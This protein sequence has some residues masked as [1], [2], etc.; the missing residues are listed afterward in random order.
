VRSSSKFL[1]FHRS[2]FGPIYQSY[3]PFFTLTQD[4]GG[5]TDIERPDAEDEE[6]AVTGF[7]RRCDTDEEITDSPLVA[8]HHGREI[9]ENVANNGVT[10]TT[11]F[12]PVQGTCS[13]MTGT[14]LAKNAVKPASVRD[15][16]AM[17]RHAPSLWSVNC[18]GVALRGGQRRSIAGASASHVSLSIS[19]AMPYFRCHSFRSSTGG[20][21]TT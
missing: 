3:G 18:A 15:A 10:P 4:D 20:T 9:V 11:V 21:S 7:L 16:R 8:F 6:I 17:R 2:E 5:W 14:D 19:A 12:S 1:A 13:V